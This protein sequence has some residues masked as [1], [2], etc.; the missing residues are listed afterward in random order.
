MSGTNMQ[1]RADVAK[2]ANILNANVAEA[3]G[4]AAVALH[5]RLAEV[6]PYRSGRARASWNIVQSEHPD[7]S[8]PPEHPGN[9]I[10][11]S[12]EEVIAARSFYEPYYERQH[13]FVP[14]TASITIEGADES[15][16][17]ITISNNLAYIEQLNNGWSKKAPAGFFQATV[18]EMEVAIQSQIAHFG[19]KI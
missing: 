10:G 9:A 13:A 17:V 1:F 12:P 2:L 8:V 3:L 6:T 4:A 7:L 5:A 11:S 14:F 16:D 15:S 18:Y 19:G